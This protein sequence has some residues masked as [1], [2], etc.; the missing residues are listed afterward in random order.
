MSVLAPGG[1]RTRRLAS[2]L[3]GTALVSVAALSMAVT[4]ASAACTTLFTGV[5][6]CL[7]NTT[8]T[9][10]TNTNGATNPSSDRVQ[11][12][13]NSAN[14]TPT[15]AATVDGYGLQ[16]SLTNAGS[17][18]IGVINSG[19]V[20][21]NQSVNALELNGNGGLV[22]YIGTGTVSTTTAGGGNAMAV[23]NIGAGG[24]TVVNNGVFSSVS[25]Y[26][27]SIDTTGGSTGTITV[28]G[29]GTISGGFGGIYAAADGVATVD[30]TSAGAIS[31]GN[32]P[33]GIGILA[34]SGGGNVLVATG[35]TVSGFD[36]IIAN[37]SGTGTMTVTTGGA[38]TG[39][40]GV[41]ISTGA[42]DGATTINAGHDVTA[43]GSYPDIRKRQ[44]AAR[45]QSHPRDHHRR[46]RDRGISNRQWRH[47]HQPDRRCAQRHEQGGS[48]VDDRRRQCDRLAHRRHGR[49]HQR[50]RHRDIGH[51]RDHH[52]H[53]GRQ[54]H[55]HG[56]Q[57]HPGGV[58]DGH[59]Q[60]RRV[61][62]HPGQ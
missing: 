52:D 8:T 60:H 42:V 2:L 48:R 17:N 18:S 28:T 43:G 54:P 41:G 45:H 5:V 24:V 21:T 11:E 6:D 23:T 40:S 34:G 4:E 31:G 47:R 53:H 26:G 22:G 50:Q 1:A 49:Q 12:F 33:N 13:N 14:V 35:S 62:R 29:T 32:V 15:I 61:R 51:D 20:T 7:A 58:D 9:N 36:A 37:T 46:G 10:N 44:R 56:Q 19:T 27:L 38:I 16:L 30:I 59:H 3:G 55:V 39:T 25:N 57:G